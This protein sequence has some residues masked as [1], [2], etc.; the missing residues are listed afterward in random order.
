[1]WSDLMFVKAFLVKEFIES[2]MNFVLLHRLT[3]V[4]IVRQS[5]LIW[6]DHGVIC[7]LLT[8][9]NITDLRAAG[10]ESRAASQAHLSFALRIVFHAH[11]QNAAVPLLLIICQHDSVSQPTGM[12]ETTG[13]MTGSQ[14]GFHRQ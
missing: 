7:L 2:F 14:A 4:I 10:A 11:K 9:R 1:M 13:T 12:T 8:Q 5:I 3:K 6:D